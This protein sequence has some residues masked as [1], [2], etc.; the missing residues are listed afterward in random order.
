MIKI[1]LKIGCDK[2][3][4]KCSKICLKLGGYGS[5]IFGQ[6]RPIFEQ[7]MDHKPL[8]FFFI[9]QKGFNKKVLALNQSL[10]KVT[11]APPGGQRGPKILPSAKLRNAHRYQK[12]VRSLQ[13]S[14]NSI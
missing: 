10:A 9:L 1:T 4:E 14:F 6:L 13:P 3:N 5:L 11:V 8:G 12:Y 2:I 7:K